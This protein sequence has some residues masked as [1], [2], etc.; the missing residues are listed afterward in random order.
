MNR[1]M[2]LT[3]FTKVAEHNGFTAAARR[4]GLSV[5]AVT[6]TVARLEDDLGA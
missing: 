6:K 5:S 4:L 3:V 2:A 1:F